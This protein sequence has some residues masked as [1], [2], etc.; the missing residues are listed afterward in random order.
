MVAAKMIPDITHIYDDGS[1]IAEAPEDV[2][3]KAVLATVIM[4]LK[5]NTQRSKYRMSMPN[6]VSVF[7]GLCARYDM[8]NSV[9]LRNRVVLMPLRQCMKAA[10]VPVLEM[11]AVLEATMINPNTSVINEK[12]RSRLWYIIRLLLSNYCNH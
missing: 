2:I 11:T 9:T 10:L 4:T 7:T 5:I 3:R 6:T 8:Q 12:P 1:S